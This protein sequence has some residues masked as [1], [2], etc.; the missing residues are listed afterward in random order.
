MCLL[1]LVE[2]PCLIGDS[3]SSDSV[4]WLI[5]GALDAPGVSDTSEAV[6]ETD[7]VLEFPM[8]F[9]PPTVPNPAGFCR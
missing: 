8:G 3:S 2:F 7:L 6:D 5:R 4:S 1:R 9:L